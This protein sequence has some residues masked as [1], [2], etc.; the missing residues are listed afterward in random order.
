MEYRQLMNFLA[1]C[2]EG[3][4]TRA[5]EKRHITQQGLSWSLAELEKELAVPLFDRRRRK[6][7]TL[8]KYGAILEQSARAYTNQHDYI[9]ETI[10]A[11]KENSVNRLSIGLSAD[12]IPPHFLADFILAYPDIDLSAKTFPLDLCQ[13][14]IKEQNL[15]IGF[16]PPPIDTDAFEA[17]PLQKDKLYFVVGKNHPLAARKSLRIAELRN[18]KVIAYATATGPNPQIL[19]LC[20]RNGIVPD[21]QLAVI[22]RNIIA[23]LCSTG[24]FV[25][26]AGEDMK[27]LYDVATIAIEDEEIFAEFYL[28]VNRHAFINQAAQTF[29]GYAKEKLGGEGLSALTL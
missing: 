12:Y 7:L 8:T 27:D 13:Q 25:A 16:F 19:G 2:E 15:Q 26:F 21:T 23:E 5:A 18:E 1:L 29:V 11:M 4:F 28:L 22:D 14:R 17:I 6:T 9:M 10:N 24:R 20:R 3:N